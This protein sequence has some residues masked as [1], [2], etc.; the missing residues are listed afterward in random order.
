[1]PRGRF[2][3]ASIGQRKGRGTTSRCLLKSLFHV[4]AAFAPRSG[5][6]D[7]REGMGGPCHGH[8]SIHTAGRQG[9]GP[10]VCGTDIHSSGDGQVRR[11]CFIESLL[12]RNNH[13]AGPAGREVSVRPPAPSLPCVLSHAVVC[14]CA[15]A[16]V[17]PPLL[18]GVGTRDS[19][20]ADFPLP[21]GRVIAPKAS[22]LGTASNRPGG[23]IREASASQGR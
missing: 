21:S 7:C 17:R 9:K 15:F 12:P 4:K 2:W 14:P 10:R 19:A 6:G 8:P 18:G 13:L 20:V 1:M 16:V 22:A 23:P 5:R 3:E 11:R